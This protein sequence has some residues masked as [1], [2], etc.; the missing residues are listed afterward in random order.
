[1]TRNQRYAFY[2]AVSSV[3]FRVRAAVAIKDEMPEFF[4]ELNGFEVTI[5]LFTWLVLRVSPLEIGKD[6]LV[7]DA[8]TDALCGSFQGLCDKIEQKAKAE[9]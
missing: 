7:I 4:R 1:M 6:I 5:E 9:N 3:P 2:Q 8:A